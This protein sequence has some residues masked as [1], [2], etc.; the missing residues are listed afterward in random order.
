MLNDH[1]KYL[2]AELFKTDWGQALEKWLREEISLIENKEEFALKIC[3]DPLNEDFR[4][5]IGIKIGLKRV[6]R[7]PQ[8][9]LTELNREDLKK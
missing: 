2:I 8:E 3:N 6:L 1:D 9:C 7:K 4:V 5:Q